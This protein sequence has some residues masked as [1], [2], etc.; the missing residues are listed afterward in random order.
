VS[1]TV[2]VKVQLAVSEPASVTVQVTVVTPFGKAVPVFGTQAT[3]A[4]GQLSIGV[5]TV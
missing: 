3:V 4:P 2:T 5:G 1:F